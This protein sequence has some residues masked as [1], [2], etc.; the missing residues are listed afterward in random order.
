M[1]KHLRIIGC[2]LLLSLFSSLAAYSQT[3]SGTITGTVVD[4]SGA[5]VPN[6]AVTIVNVSTNAKTVVKTDSN[7]SYTATPLKI[8]NYTVELAVGCRVHV[9]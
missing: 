3:D 1:T 4:H 8:G 5:V 9:A 2:L 6:V 7:G